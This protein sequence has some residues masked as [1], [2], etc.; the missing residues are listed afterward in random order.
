MYK[1]SG[2]TLIELLVVVLIIGI[3]SAVALPQYEMAVEKARFMQAVTAAKSL[4]DAEQVYYLANG[5]YSTDLNELDISF[6]NNQVKDFD[7]RIHTEP[8][9]HI[10]LLRNKQ[11]GGT[12]VWVVSYLLDGNRPEIT[13][14]LAKTVPDASKA[15]RLCKSLSAGSAPLTLEPGYD[16]YAIH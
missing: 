9:L 7:L 14:T 16:S 15:R 3:L 13:C 1:T 4:L 6:P 12:N 11:I 5:R 2:F 10:E 8:N